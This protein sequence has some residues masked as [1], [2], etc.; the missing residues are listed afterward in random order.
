VIFISV[1]DESFA[2]LTDKRLK[3]G[4]KLL[5][6]VLVFADKVIVS[7]DVEALPQYGGRSS[8]GGFPN[9]SLRDIQRL[10]NEGQR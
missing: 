10:K 4:R 3:S 1:R 8:I 9:V 6:V 5:L 7:G 2:S